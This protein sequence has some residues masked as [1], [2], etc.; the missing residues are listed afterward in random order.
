MQKIE[1]HRRYTEFVF[2]HFKELIH[3]SSR[4]TLSLK[5]KTVG[6]LR[7]LVNMFTQ[8]MG[9]IFLMYFTQKAAWLFL[10]TLQ[11]STRNRLIL[12]IAL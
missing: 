7:M 5:Q 8:Q 4:V 6:P 9:V 10:Q 2:S 11:F 12:Q 3:Y 1:N